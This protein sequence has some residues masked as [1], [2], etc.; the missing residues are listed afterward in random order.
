MIRLFRYIPL[1]LVDRAMA[2]GWAPTQ[3][4][5]DTC[6][7]HYAVL[8]EWMCACPEAWPIAEERP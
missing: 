7:G 5:R 4:L 2:L 1:R 8:C 6:H 3:A